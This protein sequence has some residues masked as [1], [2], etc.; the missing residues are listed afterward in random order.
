MAF[1]LKL[2]GFFLSL[3]LYLFTSDGSYWLW[4]KCPLHKNIV[5]YVWALK[6]LVLL[7]KST[8]FFLFLTSC[9]VDDSSGFS[10]ACMKNPQSAVLLHPP[11]IH[12]FPD[13]LRFERGGFWGFPVSA[14]SNW[15]LSKWSKKWNKIVQNPRNHVRNVKTWPRVTITI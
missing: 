7:I 14:I 12:L 6:V 2:G 13:H 10:D 1:G 3:I 5:E 4:S 9:G 11:A 15:M 8:H